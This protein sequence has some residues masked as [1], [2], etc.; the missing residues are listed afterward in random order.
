M[1]HRPC[2]T[3]NEGVNKL[4]ENLQFRARTR[5][6]FHERRPSQL[7][8]VLKRCLNRYPGTHTHRCT[9]ML[10]SRL[11]KEAFKEKILRSKKTFTISVYPRQKWK[12]GPQS[13]TENSDSEISRE[14]RAR[15]WINWLLQ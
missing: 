3:T 10:R 4:I 9:H 13:C 14:K 6:L 11:P 7:S 5:S 2:R 15:F 1:A 8:K 12:L